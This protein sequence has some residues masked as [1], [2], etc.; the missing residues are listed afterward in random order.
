MLELNNLN[1]LSSFRPKLLVLYFII[2]VVFKPLKCVFILLL[3]R[4]VFYVSWLSRKKKSHPAPLRETR[5]MTG[6]RFKVDAGNCCSINIATAENWRQWSERLGSSDILLDCVV[7]VAEFCP[8]PALRSSAETSKSL[9]AWA[10]RW[11]RVLT[12]RHPR[13]ATTGCRHFHKSW[14]PN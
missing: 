3:V 5:K 12:A 10:S 11:N 2:M 8:K 14:P 1:A 7:H 6:R 13:V 9:H 4:Y